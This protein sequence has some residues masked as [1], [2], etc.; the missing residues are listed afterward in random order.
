MGLPFFIPALVNHLTGKVY[1]DNHSPT[2]GT[3]IKLTFA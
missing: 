2:T 3:L 1:P